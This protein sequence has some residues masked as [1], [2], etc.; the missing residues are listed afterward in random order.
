[1]TDNIKARFLRDVRNHKLT[2]ENDNDVHRCIYLGRPGSSAYHFRLIT[3]PG[4]LAISG[5]MGDYTFCRLNDMFKF[6]R[7]SEM[8]NHINAQYWHEKMQ[9]EDK[10]CKTKVFS[11]NRF[12]DAV[13]STVD[14][15]EIRLG[16][17]DKI[18]K[19]VEKNLLQM[20]LSSEQEAYELLTNYES[21]DGQIFDD[22]DFNFLEY[23]MHFKWALH[24]IVWGIKQ[25]DLLKEHR[26]QADWDKRILSGEI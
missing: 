11:P 13:V 6:F 5:D 25:Y 1:M 15:W 14:E 9:S 10:N 26:T 3:F 2:I 22:L 18:K 24:A 23:S 16:D 19:D 21:P 7:D 17:A 20:Y 8:T 4:G 12:R